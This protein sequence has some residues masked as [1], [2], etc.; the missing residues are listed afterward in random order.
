VIYTFQFV[1]NKLLTALPFSFKANVKDIQTV[2]V[3]PD[4]YS[5]NAF[6]Y[7]RWFLSQ[8][9]RWE[10]VFRGDKG[11]YLYRQLTCER[12]QHPFKIV[13]EVLFLLYTL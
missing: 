7:T 8:S 9:R 4:R 5:A 3:I 12:T 13:F 2:Q 11:S 6:N 1:I 10:G